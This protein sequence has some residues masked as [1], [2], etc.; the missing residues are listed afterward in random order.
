VFGRRD[1]ASHGRRKSFDS[2]VNSNS[3]NKKLLFAVRLDAG[4]GTIRCS[5]EA[6][7]KNPL[8]KHGG[9]EFEG[10]PVVPSV[11]LAIWGDSRKAMAKNSVAKA[12][13]KDGIKQSFAHLDSSGK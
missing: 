13:V 9:L 10:R 8:P 3:R 1:I 4:T 6:A 7:I 11:L 2:S 5:H 12:Q